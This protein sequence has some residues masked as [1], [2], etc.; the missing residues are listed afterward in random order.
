MIR[1]AIFFVF[2]SLLVFFITVF[3]RLGGHKSVAI[4]RTEMAAIQLVGKKHTGAYHKIGPVI[5]EV[6]KWAKANNIPCARTYGEYIDDPRIKDEDRLQSVGGCIVTN[7]DATATLP[8]DFVLAT[9]EAGPRI[10]AVFKGAP[11]I[12]PFKVYPAVEEFME[13]NKLKAAGPVIEIY[14]FNGNDART[15]YLF[16]YTSP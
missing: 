8:P 10:V 15:E 7:V 14:E 4:E 6:E 2:S 1:Y 5:E 13:E 12:G 16:R 3:F 9:I 11:S